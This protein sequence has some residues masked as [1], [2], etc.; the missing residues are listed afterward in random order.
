MAVHFPKVHAVIRRTVGG[1]VNG[2][3]TPAAESAQEPFV[4]NIQPA[5]AGDYTRAQAVSSGRRVTAMMRLY[6]PVDASLKVAGDNGHPGDIVIYGGERWLVIG[7][8]RWD[9]MNDPDVSHMRYMIA[10]EAEQGPGEVMA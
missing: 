10:L 8:A 5:S 6:A 7:S 4:C 3:W 9:V 1:Y 2:I